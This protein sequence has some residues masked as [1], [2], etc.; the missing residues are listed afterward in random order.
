MKNHINFIYLE[1]VLLPAFRKFEL[2]KCMK[3]YG[4]HG[5][6]KLHNF[7]AIGLKE[8]ESARLF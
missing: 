8:D 7:L 6:L 1:V 2:T 3:L 5:P 4:I